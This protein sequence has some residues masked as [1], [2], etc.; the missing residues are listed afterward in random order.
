MIQET[1]GHHNQ[2]WHPVGWIGEPKGPPRLAGGRL[3]LDFANTVGGRGTGHVSEFLTGYHVLVAWAWYAGA[4]SDEEAARLRRVAERDPDEAAAAQ[5]R[6]IAFRDLVYRLFFAVARNEEPAA[7]DIDEVSRLYRV[8]LDRARL[9]RRG[10]TFDWEWSDAGDELDRP[11]WAVAWSAVQLLTSEGYGPDQGL[12]RRRWAFMPVALLR[13]H[14]K[15]DPALVQHGSL[16]KQ[17][18]GTTPDGA[19]AGRSPGSITLDTAGLL[20]SPA[21]LV[22]TPARSARSRSAFA[23]PDESAAGSSA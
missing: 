13:R 17:R 1:T 5:A 2:Q 21:S 11:L 20:G 10:G 9:R 8:A 6:A 4:L 23:D 18:E 7:A 22:P 16:R 19:A 3:C 12:S 15:P 14:Q